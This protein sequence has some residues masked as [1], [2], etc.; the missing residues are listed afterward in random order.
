MIFYEYKQEDMDRI[1]E[2]NNAMSVDREKNPEKW[3]K[4][5]TPNYTMI[6]EIPE[7]KESMRGLALYEVENEEQLQHYDMFLR[8]TLVRLGIKG[9]IRGWV[10]LLDSF[11]QIDE[12]KTLQKNP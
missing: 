6:G 9:G 2:G 3:P 10:P 11:K 7:M 1:I 5:L 4:Q 8:S 12:W